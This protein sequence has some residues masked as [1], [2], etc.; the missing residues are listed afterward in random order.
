MHG[1]SIR[2][3]FHRDGQTPDNV[4]GIAKGW[5]DRTADSLTDVGTKDGV[6]DPPSLLVLLVA[7]GSH[8]LGMCGGCG[9]VNLAEFAED[10]NEAMA[11]LT[12]YN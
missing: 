10:E 7:F 3:I 4:D 1:G 9:W 2:N 8:G 6:G 12:D 11:Q 5:G